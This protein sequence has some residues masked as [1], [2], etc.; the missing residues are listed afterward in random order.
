MPRRLLLHLLALLLSVGPVGSYAHGLVHLFDGGPFHGHEK[1]AHHGDRL[2]PGGGK[3]GGPGE[4]GHGG[5]G[6]DLFGAHAPLGA[7]APGYVLPSGPDVPDAT[8]PA[9]PAWPVLRAFYRPYLQ[10]A[11]PV[12]SLKLA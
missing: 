1:D 6:C 7:G 3:E 4:L 2:V 8:V 5:S 12:D 11:P 10:R 9:T